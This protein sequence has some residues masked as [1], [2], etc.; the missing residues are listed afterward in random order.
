MANTIKRTYKGQEHHS[1]LFLFTV[2]IEEA[3]GR[4]IHFWSTNGDSDRLNKFKKRV[5]PVLRSCGV[6]QCISYLE[7]V[8][9]KGKSDW[10][11]GYEYQ[12]FRLIRH[13]AVHN[14]GFLLD[15]RADAIREALSKLRAGEI[16]DRKGK[17]V[18]PYY[19]IDTDGRIL[20]NSSAL[21]RCKVICMEFLAHNGLAD[22]P[23]IK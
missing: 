9:P 10:P 3:I 16:K 23:P 7:R 22:L 1:Q 2:A 12:N 19:D 6:A 20:L 13:C 5:A 4:E 14:Y 8:C 15:N 17:P 21:H 18:H 11:G